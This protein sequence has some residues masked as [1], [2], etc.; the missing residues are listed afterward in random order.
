MKKPLLFPR[1]TI[2]PGPL[3]VL[4]VVY[5]LDDSGIVSAML[6]A[7]LFH[8]LGHIAALRICGLNIERLTLGYLGLRLDYSGYASRSR[9][10][11]AALAGPFA[12]LLYTVLAA[13][14]GI[15]WRKSAAL[16]LLLTLFNL[17]PALPLDGGRAAEL[18]FGET[19]AAV[20]GRVTALLLTALGLWTLA[21]HGWSGT[22]APGL[23]L[24]YK[25]MARK[26][27][28][29]PVAF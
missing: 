14:G 24:L 29:K 25:S 15:F 21:L 16:S 4:A 3:L 8:E 28:E 7:V 9:L 19:A 23:Y 26:N 18:V 1:L 20:T 27:T 17:L 6:P 2:P 5:F 10:L 12:G 13:N 22:L 11:F